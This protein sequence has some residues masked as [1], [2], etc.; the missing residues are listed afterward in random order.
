MQRKLLLHPTSVRDRRRHT[1]RSAA[2]HGPSAP[3]IVE[4]EARSEA[5]LTTSP[6]LIAP[7]PVLT[8]RPED[9]VID[10][11]DALEVTSEVDRESVPLAVVDEAAPIW[12]LPSATASLAERATA[13]LPVE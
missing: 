12:L 9:L 3:E 6:R 11:L 4:I 10:P 13:P 2:R 1:S 5:S 8:V 7:L